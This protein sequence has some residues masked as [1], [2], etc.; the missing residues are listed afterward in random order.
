MK[1]NSISD[2]FKNNENALILYKYI[3]DPTC[4]EISGVW[5]KKFPELRIL[6]ERI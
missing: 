6:D 4:Y 2:M 3:L 5:K 1:N